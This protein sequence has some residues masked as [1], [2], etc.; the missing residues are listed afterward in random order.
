MTTIPRTIQAARAFTLVELLVVIGVLL[1][2][3]TISIG[4]GPRSRAVAK[5]P[6]SNS[7]TRSTVRSKSSPSPPDAP[8]RGDEDQISF[9]QSVPNTNDTQIESLR[10]LFGDD[11]LARISGPDGSRYLT[12]PDAAIFVRQA[13]ASAPV[14]DILAGVPERFV[15]TIYGNPPSSGG[16]GGPGSPGGGP[17]SVPGGVPAAATSILDPWGNRVLFVHPDNVVAQRLYGRCV[18]NR[19]YFLSAG[20]DKV[21]GLGGDLDATARLKA[22]DSRGPGL[23]AFLEAAL[24]DN[25]TSYPVGPADRTEAAF[26][27]L[28]SVR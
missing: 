10:R 21:Y 18:G 1:L 4:L 19:P 16:P 17:G 28:R 25:I 24:D 14:D 11:S 7:S 20:P 23:R 6:P 2:L 26:N 9:W 22:S 8:A 5:P 3:L 27:E 15:E 13:R 12:R